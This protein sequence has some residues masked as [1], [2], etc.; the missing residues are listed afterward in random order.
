MQ[1]HAQLISQK[2]FTLQQKTT[3]PICQYLH[4]KC[5]VPPMLSSLP[6]KKITAVQS[7]Y[8][9]VVFSSAHWECVRVRA[10]WGENCVVFCQIGVAFNNFRN[11]EKVMLLDPIFYLVL[12]LSD[13]S[14][15]SCVVL[16]QNK[17]KY[18]CVCGWGRGPNYIR[19]KTLN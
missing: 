17:K 19:R 7:K 10:Y 8:N 14:L 16:K 2:I 11:Q 6:I 1:L 3:F 5:F 9:C 15:F 12:F 4:G 13:L 18:W